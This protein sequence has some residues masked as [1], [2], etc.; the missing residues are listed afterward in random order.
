M[1]VRSAICERSDGANTFISHRDAGG[2]G[3][4]IPRDIASDTLATECSS[5][6]NASWYSILTR[7]PAGG[8]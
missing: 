8:F 7:H 6:P 5:F 1:S 3:A 2:S 4:E